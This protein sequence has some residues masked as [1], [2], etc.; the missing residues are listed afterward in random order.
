MTPRHAL[1][2]AAAAAVLIVGITACGSDDDATTDST[3]AAA[4]APSPTGPITAATPDEFVA[5]IGRPD[6]TLIDVR[7]PEEF[8]AGHIDGAI[9]IDFQAP[10]FA[11]KIGAL[12]PAAAYAIYC[13]SGNRSGQAEAQMAA[14]GFTDMTDLTGGITAWTEAGMQVVT[15]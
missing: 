2:A 7:T 11:D 9:N 5:V 1:R 12:D 3:V 13:H 14:M 4:A 8:A 10:D 15:G 6:I